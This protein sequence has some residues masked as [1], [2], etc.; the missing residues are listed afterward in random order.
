M[1]G[2]RIRPR[3]PWGQG[4]RKG[5]SINMKRILYRQKNLPGLKLIPSEK[6]LKHERVKKGFESG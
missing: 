3:P 2:N 6:L 4:W 5:E 1:R